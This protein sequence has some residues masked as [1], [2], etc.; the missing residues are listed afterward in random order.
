MQPPQY[1]ASTAT[2]STTTA[3]STSTKATAATLADPPTST[4]TECPP[5]VT[6]NAVSSGTLRPNNNHNNLLRKLAS[7]HYQSYTTAL[8][9][10]IAV[11][12]FLLLL[13]IL[14]FAGIYHQRDRGGSGGHFGDKK[15][16]ELAE[17][18]SCSSSSG[19]GHHFESKHA[20]VD[21]VVL[22]ASQQ[23]LHPS[24]SAAAIELPLQEFRSSPT[25]GTKTRP[26]C[27]SSVQQPP[28]YTPSENTEAP[29]EEQET[30][31]P[32]PSP[33]RSSPSIPDPPPP[34]KTLPPPSCNQ[35]SSS[36]GILRQQGCPQTP[37]T[38]KKRVQI[39]EIS[40]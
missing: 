32:S 10:T 29:V 24:A 28:I 15:K 31:S 9:V 27:I 33:R 38:M 40:V 36:V 12:C 6:T 3:P 25:S 30:Q 1:T 34:P 14:I 2:T 18:G 39:Q 8:T 20:L 4:S 11:G 22:A 5:N 21:H 37:G 7:S 26:N 19:D 16:E 35:I 13:N 23:H 17:A